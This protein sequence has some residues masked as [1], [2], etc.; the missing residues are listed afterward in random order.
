MATAVNGKSARVSL[1][2]QHQN[3]D[4]LNKIVANILGRVGCGTCGRIAFLDLHF[5]G[6]PGPDLTKEGVISIQTEGF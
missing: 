6:D 3:I 1:N 4:T 5:Q 2:P